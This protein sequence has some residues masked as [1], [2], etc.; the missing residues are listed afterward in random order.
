MRWTISHGTREGGPY[1]CSYHSM[2]TLARHLAHVLPAKDWR[3]IHRLFR[4][5]A[6]LPVGVHHVEASYIADIL[7]K[8]ANHRLMPDTSAAVAHDLADTAGRA[9]GTIEPWTWT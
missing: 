5:P 1:Y 6:G 9:A 8:A 7:Y 2:N 3:R 4:R